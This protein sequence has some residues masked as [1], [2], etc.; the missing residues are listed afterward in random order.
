[1]R[2]V[3]TLPVY[4]KVA[5]D[6][7]ARI[8]RNEIPTGRK[9]SGRS[10]LAGEYNV[11]PETI[12]KAMKLL[13]DMDIVEVKHGNGIYVGSAVRAGEF[14]EK[15]GLRSTIKELKEELVDLM[16]QRDAIEEKMNEVVNAIIDYT[17]RF[18]S[19]EFIHSEDPF[20]DGG[21][22]GLGGS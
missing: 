2:T 21:D 11:S 13:S 9:I 15:Y 3:S 8:S 16:R 12:R 20:L 14:L 4:M 6:M 19:S 10:T 1:M 17:S 5:V 22:E 18:K 7:A